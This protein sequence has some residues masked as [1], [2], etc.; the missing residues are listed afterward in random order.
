MQVSA[1]GNTMR[2]AGRFDGRSTGEVRDTLHELIETYDDVVVELSEVESVDA[3]ALRLLAAASAL[4]ERDG[5]T[6]T[7]RGASPSLRRV[8]TF[9]RVRRVFSVER[10]AAAV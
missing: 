10:D 3:T 9:T 1:S 5:R 6:L 2:L 8:L 7:L 4:M